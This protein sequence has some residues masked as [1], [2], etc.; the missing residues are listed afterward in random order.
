MA[1]KALPKKMKEVKFE[2]DKEAFNGPFTCHKKKT[3]LTQ[4]KMSVQGNVF[5]YST[6][7]CQ[8]CGED[9]LDSKQAERLEMIWT[10]EKLMKNSLLSMK[11]SLNY[12][13]KM[14]FLRFPKELTKDWKKGLEA[15]MKIIDKNKILI[16]VKA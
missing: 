16:E 12:D 6:W 10:F 14:F 11:R 13:G 7:R 9:Y 3:V 8:I 4:K 15:E 1:K 5:S 2:I